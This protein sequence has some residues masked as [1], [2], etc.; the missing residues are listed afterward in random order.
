MVK[1]IK[2]II[3]IGLISS[4]MLLIPIS[5]NAEWKQDSNQKWWNSED[6]S[7][8]VGWK[9]INSKWYY[10]GQDGYLLQNTTTL[11]GFKVDNNGVWIQN[12]T[13]TN[14]NSNNAT[15]TSST[16]NAVSSTSNSNNLTNLTN[17]TDNSKT[18][19]GGNTTLNNT[20]SISYTDNSNTTNNVT[21]D[22]SSKEEK[23]YYKEVEKSQKQSNS[24]MKAY[25]EKQLSQAKADLSEVKQKLV[26]VKSQKT[27]QTY[28]K[29]PITEEWGFKY[30]ADTTK[31]KQYEKEVTTEQANVEYYE[32]LVK[33]YS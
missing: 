23:N 10:F 33:Q 11:D 21:V 8:S 2:K 19:S 24:A 20:G 26:N 18:N 7:W 13:T 32:K 16:N 5:A 29:D 4:S 6:N 30:E 28:A 3:S 27:I 31:V 15:N 12:I 17:N 25:Y 1:S 14:T 9:E 22:N